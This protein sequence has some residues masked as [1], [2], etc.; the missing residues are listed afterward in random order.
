MK[1]V[2]LILVING[3]SEES[4]VTQKLFSIYQQISIAV[5]ISDL[6][7]LHAKPLDRWHYDTPLSL[8]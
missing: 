8:M 1:D 4:A 2:W 5:T 3:L 7:Y 6:V